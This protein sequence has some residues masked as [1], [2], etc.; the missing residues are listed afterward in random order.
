M[1]GRPGRPC[2]VCAHPSRAIID[3]LLVE[4]SAN[5]AI[6]RQF[7]VDKDAVW[8]HHGRHL[9]QTLVKAH[10]ASEIARADGLLAR[11]EQLYARAEQVYIEAT[12]QTGYRAWTTQ[13]Q[14]IREARETVEILAKLTGELRE[15]AQ[16]NVFVTSE[17]HVVVQQIRDALAPWPE[18]RDAV[19][20][21]LRRSSEGNGNGNGDEVAGAPATIPA[22]NG[23]IR[24]P[25]EGM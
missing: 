1:P 14:S 11:M 18:A 3:K 19:A 13:L 5:R 2:T 12:Q 6:A 16:I 8:R 22:P 10:A 24:R 21:A 23:E 7:G 15:Q 17:W 9:P 20:A 25:P 4:G